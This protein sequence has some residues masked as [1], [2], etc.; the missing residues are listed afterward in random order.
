MGQ[1]DLLL[2][3]NHLYCNLI[4]RYLFEKFLKN[5]GIMELTR[6]GPWNFFLHVLQVSL[7]SWQVS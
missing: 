5:D 7:G 2:V 4:R 6:Q 1:V 3:V